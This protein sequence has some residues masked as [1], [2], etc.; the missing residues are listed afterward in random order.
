MPARI[1][2]KTVAL[3]AKVDPST[4]CL[5]L[6]NSPN[7]PAETRERIIAIADKIGYRRDPMLGALAA[8][9]RATAKPAFHGVLGWMVNSEGGY[10]WWGPPEYREYF[11]GAE[12]CATQLGYQLVT[13]DLDEY[14]SNSKRLNGVL[15]ARNIRGILVCP[16]PQAHTLLELVI[17]DL[18]AVTF[19]YTLQSPPLHRVTSHHY[20]AMR[21]TLGELRARGYQRIGYAIPQS[22]NERLDRNYM[23]GYLLEQS[24]WPDTQRLPPFVGEP[25]LG[26]FRT[27][28]RA[29]RPDALVTTHYIFPEMISALGIKVPAK[30][31]VAIISLAESVREYAGIDE[32]SREVGRVAVGQLAALVERGEKGLP[33][34]PQSVLVRGIWCEGQTLRA[35]A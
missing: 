27:W 34:R 22:H 7:L 6:N 5:A 19:G 4:V 1:T 16:Q 17:E 28:L 30:L 12:E 14:R 23:A 20:A 18:S 35:R 11:A 32:D 10:D 33:A 13:L 25:R 15:R 9:R 2:Q 21:E 26:P 31:G 29:T 8:Y 24:D 3:A